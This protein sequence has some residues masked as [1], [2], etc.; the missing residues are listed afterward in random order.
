VRAEH[1]DGAGELGGASGQPLELAGDRTG[2]RLG[3]EALEPR[4]GLGA[5]RD[6]LRLDRGEK[7]VEVEGVAARGGV[8][9]GAERRRR[10]ADPGADD[11][12][13]RRGPERPWTQ[14]ALPRLGEE[15][16]EQRRVAGGLAAAHRRKH[17]QR[18]PVQAPG[19]VAVPAQ[20][21]RVGPVDVVDGQ[22]E[23]APAREVGDEPEQPVQ[24]RVGHVVAGCGVAA[25]GIQRPQGQ[26]G[27]VGGQARP[28]VRVAA[29]ADGSSS[30]R[31]T[32]QPYACSSGAAR[33][34]HCMPRAPASS[35][36]AASRLVLP[37]PAAPSTITS[38]P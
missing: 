26:P 35:P 32:P 13:R 21:R 28:V 2:D 1:G 25:G 37:I 18:E 31:T 19:H 11:R 16:V 17:D 33:E 9:G 34:Q 10:V 36:A 8:A 38:A 4:R 23:R 20:G 7:R 12:L 22:R 15:A 30:W 24:R 6:P 14:G 29:R 5:W 3:A 27:G